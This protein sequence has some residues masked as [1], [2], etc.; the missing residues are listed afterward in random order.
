MYEFTGAIMESLHPPWRLTAPEFTDILE[1]GRRDEAL[2]YYSKHWLLCD[3]AMA[4]F[5]KPRQL[6]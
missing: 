5:N 4:Q 3:Q 6:P 2:T 1:T